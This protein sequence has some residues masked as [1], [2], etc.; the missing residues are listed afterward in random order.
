MSMA[1]CS[2]TSSAS[3]AVATAEEALEVLEHSAIDIVLTDLKLPRSNGVGTA[4]TGAR[5]A[6]GNC[7]RDVDAVRHNR[8]RRG[9]HSPGRRGL[10]DEALSHRG[11]ALPA[12]TRGARRRTPAGEPPAP[13]AI[14]HAARVR[15]ADR[16][17]HENAA[18]L[19]ND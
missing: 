7:R 2:R 1:E 14:A 8:I 12:R 9:G 10:R 5:P 6:S 15:R 4:E 17:L 3:S 16:R 13:R 11:I 18:R 19:Q